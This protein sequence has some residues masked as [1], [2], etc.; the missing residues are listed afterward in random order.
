MEVPS[1][2][3]WLEG[4][5]GG[6]AWLAGLADQVEQAATRWE[7]QLGPAFPGA[8]VSYVVAARRADGSDA[9]LKFQFPG[10]DCRTE[11]DALRAWDGEGAIE[12]LGHDRGRWELLLERARPG[13]R[14]VEAPAGV[15]LTVLADLTERTW[16]VPPPDAPFATLADHGRHWMLDLVD[17]WE[18]V[19]RPCP[20]SLLD[21]AIA[22]LA[23]VVDDQPD[24]VIVNQDLHVDNVLAAEREPWLVADPKPLVGDRAFSA[25]SIVRC[26]QLGHSR[27]D[28]ARRLDWLCDRLAL[29]RGRALHWSF[30]QT[31]CWG[32][33]DLKGG[34][35]QH[36]E[37]ATWLAEL[38]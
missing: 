17:H 31:L 2:L 14:L 5:R 11:A 26:W 16:V 1:E 15:A 7:L 4:L 8:H 29:D 38:R 35:P 20:R 9:V 34:R 36:L 23:D 19:D 21:Q 22:A 32:L 13:T 24:P 3:R 37:T 30:G 28:V 25:A 12:L 6:A 27:A 18:A 10:E 33:A